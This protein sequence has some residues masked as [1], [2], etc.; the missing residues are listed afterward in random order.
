MLIL[1]IHLTKSSLSTRLICASSVT[2]AIEAA[3]EKIQEAQRKISDKTT[4]EARSLTPLEQ[5][6]RTGRRRA[7]RPIRKGRVLALYAGTR[8]KPEVSHA[9][10]SLSVLRAKLRASTRHAAAAAPLTREWAQRGSPVIM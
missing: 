8:P 2:P 6:S 4:D 9:C 10:R 5:P 7:L 1:N 3:T